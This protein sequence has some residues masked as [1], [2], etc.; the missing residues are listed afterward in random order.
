MKLYVKQKV[1]SFRQQF[2]VYDAAGS[3][4]YNVE[5][6]FFTFVPKLHIYDTSGRERA[7]LQGRFSF[8]PRY[9]V[10]VGGMVV[11]EIVKDFTWLKPRYHIEGN[12]W[13][14]EGEF[15]A[16][17]Y[18]ITDGGRKIATISKQWFTWGDTYELDIAD[19]AD[20]ITALAVMLAIDCVLQA[21]DNAAASATT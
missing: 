21:N 5:G 2:S 20:E 9:K 3:P 19:A 11:A 16:H 7:M 10:I 4:R 6:E 1:F 17:D 15:W 13:Q 12:G 14:I 18:T 8:M